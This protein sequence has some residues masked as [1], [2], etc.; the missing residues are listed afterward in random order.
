MVG[1]QLNQCCRGTKCLNAHTCHVCG[2]APCEADCSWQMMKQRRSEAEGLTNMLM[3]LKDP[4]ER[5]RREE[6]LKQMIRERSGDYD[7]ENITA[8][9]RETVV[10]RLSPFFD[11]LD[12][13]NIGRVSVTK[14]KVDTARSTC[15]CSAI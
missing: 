5:A 11:Y 10:E 8:E 2:E 4:K 6:E 3:S 15:A 12:P 13:N 1:Y 9:E 14:C 7:K